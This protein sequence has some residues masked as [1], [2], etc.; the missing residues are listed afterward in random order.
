MFEGLVVPDF[1]LILF[2]FIIFAICSL[3]VIGLLVS[4]SRNKSV[5]GENG[6]ANLSPWSGENELS[7]GSSG[8][9]VSKSI[10]DNQFPENSVV[11]KTAGSLKLTMDFNNFEKSDL[12]LEL[13]TNKNIAKTPPGGKMIPFQTSAW[14]RSLY[15]VDA[16]PTVIL[17]ELKDAYIDI[18]LANELVWLSDFVFHA[19][20]GMEESYLK[21]CRSIGEHLDTAIFQAI[22]HSE[23]LC[24][25]AKLLFFGRECKS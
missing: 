3:S 23:N 15:E 7:K 8:S 10:S 5:V 20:Q 4:K 19:G 21:L 2:F 18:R 12:F 1:S 14:D 13:E 22:D 6:Q 11:E 9:P 16:L 25:P 24:E 17:K